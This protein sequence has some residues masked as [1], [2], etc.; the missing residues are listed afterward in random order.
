MR[1]LGMV[2]AEVLTCP[3]LCVSKLA[4]F[5]TIK[6]LILLEIKM[7]FTHV[8]CTSLL[9]PNTSLDSHAKGQTHKGNIYVFMHCNQLLQFAVFIYEVHHII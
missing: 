6:Y 5:F 2:L 3:C 1:G 9:F 4:V 7:F 8:W